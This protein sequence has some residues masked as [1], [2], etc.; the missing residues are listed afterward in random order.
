MKHLFKL[1]LALICC[2]PAMAQQKKERE[3]HYTSSLQQMITVY[4]GNIFVN[5]KKTFTFSR[6]SINYSSKRNRLIED[7]RSVF[8]FLEIN[9]RPN[10]N[11]LC[12]FNV[13]NSHADSILTAISSDV[14][15]WDHDGNLE[16][17]GSEQTPAYPSH[18]SMYYV[19][20]RFYEIKKGKLTYDAE[21]TEATDKKVNGVFLTEPMDSNGKPK[22][23]AVGKGKKR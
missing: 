5:G 20:S 15:D 7:G 9:D 4:Q 22:V 10:K 8:L 6:D 1:C 3:L 23:I 19:A 2:Q 21:L 17:G 12:V 14:K 16:F 11:K 13:E 18:D